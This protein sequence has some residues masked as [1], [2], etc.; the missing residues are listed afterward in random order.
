[1]IDLWNTFVVEMGERA[2]GPLSMRLLVQ[3]AVASVLAIRDGLKDAREGRPAFLWSIATDPEHR[4]Y[5]VRDG[6]KS[7]GKVFLL[8]IALDFVYLL[9]AL[10]EFLLRQSLI[11][12]LILAMIP[13]VVLRGLTTRISGLLRRP[14]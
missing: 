11:L 4:S 1:M 7:A 12:A 6:W 9:I 13:Y 2:A 14:T 10:Q 8:V 5:L 3:P